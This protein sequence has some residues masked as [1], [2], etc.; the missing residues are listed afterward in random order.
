MGLVHNNLIYQGRTQQN[1][2]DNEWRL[3]KSGL[4]QHIIENI[5][6]LTTASVPPT[7][8]NSTSTQTHNTFN[9]G[10]WKY[11]IQ[12]W[13]QK[14]VALR[15]SNYS[16]SNLSLRGEHKIDILE[17]LNSQTFG[18]QSVGPPCGNQGTVVRIH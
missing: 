9:R 8:P 13:A 17:I 12:L 1:Y 4:G 5:S 6:P 10:K 16:L 11:V 18:D 3:G 2:G 15:K 7:L 14:S